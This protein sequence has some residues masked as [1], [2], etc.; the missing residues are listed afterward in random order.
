MIAVKPQVVEE[1]VREISGHITAKQLI[2]SVSGLGAN[3]PDRKKP[4]AERSRDTC[5]AQY[6]LPAGRWNDS[7]LQRQ[8]RQ[9]KGRRYDLPHV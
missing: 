8:A 4:V 3:I 2:V 7:D 6:A 1:V 5:H 9:R